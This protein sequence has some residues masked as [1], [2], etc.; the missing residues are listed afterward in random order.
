MP[1]DASA[2]P[3]G[4]PPCPRRPNCASSGHER[5]ERRV[6]PIT[7]SLPLNRALDRMD[8]VIARLGGKMITRGRDSLQ[9]EFRTFLGFVD[10]VDVFFDMY[11]KTIHLRS[12]SR[13]G[14]W[15]FGVNRRR[16]ERIR[17]LYTHRPNGDTP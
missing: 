5:P 14:W 8:A 17:E 15:D 13:L 3:D 1:P 6:E 9:A 11:N 4:L 10:D 2:E 7:L 16:L 12:A